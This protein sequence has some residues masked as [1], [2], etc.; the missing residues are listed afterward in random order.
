M[1]YKYLQLI[2]GEGACCNAVS[3]KVA[4][5]RATCVS[6]GKA[7]PAA[8]AAALGARWHTLR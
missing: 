1:T 3:Y 2:I 8:A 5:L 4:H 6:S 7:G